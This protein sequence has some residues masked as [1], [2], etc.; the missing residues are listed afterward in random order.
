MP[1]FQHPSPLPP[2]WHQNHEDQH[3]DWSKFCNALQGLTLY[4]AMGY[5]MLRCLVAVHG[6]FFWRQWWLLSVGGIWLSLSLIFR[7]LFS[8]SE[9]LFVWVKCIH[10]SRRLFWVPVH[11]TLISTCSSCCHLVHDTNT[12][13]TSYGYLVQ[14]VSNARLDS[15][16]MV[17]L[18]RTKWQLRAC[19]QMAGW[20]N[21]ATR[22]PWQPLKSHQYLCLQVCEEVLMVK[23]SLKT[24]TGMAKVDW[25]NYGF[26]SCSVSRNLFH[27]PQLILTESIKVL[28]Q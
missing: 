26:K 14:R 5:V 15:I 13:K 25:S 20:K 27:A 11:D 10:L 16:I 1:I 24:N 7:F 2:S 17:L 23:V 4:I 22:G 8:S 18:S 6:D 21:F 28:E 12:I 9:S 19:L 3:W